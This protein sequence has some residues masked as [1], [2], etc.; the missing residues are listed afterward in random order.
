MSGIY[1]T[2]QGQVLVEEQYRRILKH[3]PVPNRQFQLPTRQGSTFV[4][5]CG[6]ESA[7]PVLLLHGSLANSASWMGDVAL[8]AQRCRVYAIDVIGEPGLSAPS[9]P[10]LDSDAYA[11]WLDDVMRGLGLE[12]T[13]LVGVSLGG[14]LA[15]D[16]ATRRPER[17]DRLALICPGGVGRQKMAILLKAAILGVCGSWGKR[18]LRESILGRMPSDASPALRKFGE[19]IA[20]IHKSTWPRKDRLPIFEDAALKRL[21]MPVLAIVGGKDALLDSLET[22]R[23]IEAL[24]ENAEV[25]YIHAAGHFIPGQGGVIA[26][27]LNHSGSTRVVPQHPLP[28]IHADRGASVVS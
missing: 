8:W 14:W 22:Q 19:F 21:T 26:E 1:K 16:Y 24:V 10:A 3:W 18:K 5:A 28:F 6:E 17:I 9:R 27:F 12:H 13:A 7:P 2:S 20:L 23:R 25:R 4:I 11:Q 15:L